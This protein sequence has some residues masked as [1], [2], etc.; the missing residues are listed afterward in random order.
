MSGGAIHAHVPVLDRTVRSR[1]EE[2]VHRYMV[3][4]TFPDGLRL[5]AGLRPRR[6]GRDPAGLPVDDI[7]QVRVLD[8]YF[9]AAS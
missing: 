9:Y 8:P 2:H 3:V 7:T 1:K 5:S 4:R 6:A